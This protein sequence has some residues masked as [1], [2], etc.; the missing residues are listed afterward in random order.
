LISIENFAS[1]CRRADRSRLKGL[2]L[3]GRSIQAL[4]LERSNTCGDIALVYLSPE[5]SSSSSSSSNLSSSP[6]VWLRDLFGKWNFLAT[7]FSNYYRMMLV[8]LGLE[9]W[10]L[11]FTDL[12]VDPFMKPWFHLFIPKRL[13]LDEREMIKYQM[14]AD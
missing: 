4:I 7:N 3:V 10:Q 2:S 13:A 11:L 9:S 5:S 14:S 6:E 1:T 8:H 12:S